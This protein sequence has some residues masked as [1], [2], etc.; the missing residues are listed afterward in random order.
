MESGITVEVGEI[1]ARHGESRTPDT[2]RRRRFLRRVRGL[3][4]AECSHAKSY[5]ATA[6]RGARDGLY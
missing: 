2:G 6:K 1:E 3:W 4:L 5:S